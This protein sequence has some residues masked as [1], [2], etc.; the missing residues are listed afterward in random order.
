MP[1]SSFSDTF[2][3]AAARRHAAFGESDS[4]DSSKPG[5]ATA[6]PC[7]RLSSIVRVGRPRGEPVDEQGDEQ[8]G[9][10]HARAA[11][12]GPHRHRAPAGGWMS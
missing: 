8:R 5:G 4:A 12:D 9:G 7:L 11:E 2:P 1:L 3:S 10:E 6:W